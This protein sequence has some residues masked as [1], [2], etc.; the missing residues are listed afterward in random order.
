DVY[1]V[2]I[3]HS[4]GQKIIQK[5]TIIRNGVNNTELVLP[6]NLPVGMYLLTTRDNNGNLL[7]QSKIFKH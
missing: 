7:Y 1:L 3:Y 5:K 6:A 4:T 2:E